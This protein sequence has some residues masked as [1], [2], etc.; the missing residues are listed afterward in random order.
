MPSDLK[1]NTIKKKC[2]HYNYN[3]KKTENI[4]NIYVEICKAGRHLLVF[5]LK[6]N[7]LV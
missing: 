3:F 5:V 6:I 2:T 1:D 7:K 4:N